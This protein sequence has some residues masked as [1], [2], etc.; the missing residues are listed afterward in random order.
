MIQARF[1]LTKADRSLRAAS[2]LLELDHIDSAASRTYYGFFYV[3]Q[4]LLDTQGLRFSS[5]G[6]VLAQYGRLFAKTKL[7]DPR[8]HRTLSE[9]FQVRQ[10]ADYTISMPDPEVIEDLIQEG[11]RFIDE[12]FEYIRTTFYPRPK[13][14]DSPPSPED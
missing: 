8:F 6:Q 14:D 2:R 10:S 13:Y 4:A 5:H 11:H 3:A 12:A 1:L 7:L 9:A